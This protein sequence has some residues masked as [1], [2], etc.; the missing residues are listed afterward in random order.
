[1]NEKEMKDLIF[2]L[3]WFPH[4]AHHSRNV[5]ELLKKHYPR[6]EFEKDLLVFT[7]NYL[8]KP[9]EGSPK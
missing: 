7:E 1:M 8:S 9:E 5:R 4:S 6:A 2:G 3:S